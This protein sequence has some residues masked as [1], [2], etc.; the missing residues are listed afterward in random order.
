MT[1]KTQEELKKLKGLKELKK[2]KYKKDK[3][4]K[5]IELLKKDGIQK[6]GPYPFTLPKDLKKKLEKFKK[7]QYLLKLKKKR[8]KNLDKLTGGKGGRTESTYD[9]QNKNLLFKQDMLGKGVEPMKKGGTIKVYAKGG[10]VRKI[11]N[12]YE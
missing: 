11:R 4:D 6:L 2:E 9:N 5:L 12:V 8:D 3:I 1:I 7:E 10:G